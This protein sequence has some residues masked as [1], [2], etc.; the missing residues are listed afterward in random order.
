MF[1][2]RVYWADIPISNGQSSDGTEIEG[3]NIFGLPSFIID[4]LVN[5]P[6]CRHSIRTNFCLANKMP[7][8]SDKV[9]HKNNKINW[10][11]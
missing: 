7:S 3:I 9:T 6:A 8:T 2:E 1:D 4:V 11:E 5:K 10:F